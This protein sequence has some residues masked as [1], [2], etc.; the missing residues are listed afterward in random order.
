M[1]ETAPTLSE[2]ELA[3]F[4]RDGYLVVPSLVSG[5]RCDE[6]RRV[7]NEHLAQNLAP[8]EYEVDV[9]Y[10]G[11]PKSA[12]AAGGQTPRRLLHA[13]ARHSVFRD[14]ATGPAV[15]GYL[16]QLFDSAA[17]ELSQCHHNCIMT[18]HP[19]YSSA[20]LW[21]Q[22]N[23]YWSFDRQDLIS[24]WLAVGDENRR[25]GCLRV[26]PGSHRLE[27]DPGRFDAALF[28]RTDI[29]DNKEL[30]AGARSVELKRGDM[31]FFHSKLFHAAGRNLSE[32]TKLS[33]VF[34]YHDAANRPIEGTRSARFPG[35]PL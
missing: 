25:N 27:I 15:S 14:W 24:A 28:L 9:Q 26:I 1:V 6:I 4:H 32:E 13:Y 7:A 33:V 11:S 34:T 18:K 20:T 35:V 17:V 22:D 12:D 5:E 3:A 23:R 8:I 29:A 19:G 2:V 30:L 10:P 21:H 31:L 16:F